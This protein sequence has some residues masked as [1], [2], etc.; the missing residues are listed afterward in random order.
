VAATVAFADGPVPHDDVALGDDGAEQVELEPGSWTLTFTADGYDKADLGVVVKPGTTGQ[1]ARVTMHPATVQVTRQQV[2]I[3]QTIHFDFDKA[4]IRPDS[5]KLLDEIARVLKENPQVKL[6]QVNGY[7]S[8]EGTAQYNLDLSQR[9]VESVVDALVQ[10]GIDRKRLIAKGHGEADPS[11]AND[12][13]AH[14]AENRRVVFVILKQD[15]DE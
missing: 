8:D 9:R 7:T 4:T 13:E 11:V 14:R 15:G 10:R 12:T 1:E 2:M 5:S 6:V 3:T